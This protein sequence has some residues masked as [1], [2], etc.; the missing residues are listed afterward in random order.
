MNPVLFITMP[1]SPLNR[2][3]TFPV[4][5]ICPGPRQYI[6]SADMAGGHA[7]GGSYHRDHGILQE[8]TDAGHPGAKLVFVPGCQQTSHVTAVSARLLYYSDR[9]DLLLFGEQEGDGQLLYPHIN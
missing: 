7:S 9:L 1:E 3:D 8:P 4:F 2:R 6:E 5:F